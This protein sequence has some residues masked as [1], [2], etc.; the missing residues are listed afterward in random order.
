MEPIAEAPPH[1]K[2]RA[3]GVVYLLYFLIA[4]PAQLLTS[5]GL[6]TLGKG[7]NLVGFA[8]YIALTLLLYGLFKPVN[9]TLSLLAA[10]VSLL[11]SMVGI[12]D[13][14]HMAPSRISP[15]WF[16]GPYCILIGW[17]ILRSTFLPRILGAVMLL[18]GVS[19]LAYLSPAVAHAFSHWIE[20]LGILAEGSLMLWLLVKGV[21]ERRWQEQAGRQAALQATGTT[22]EAPP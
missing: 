13:L 5:R 21:D 11:G 16:F 3:I 10:I 20:G 1:S 22:V 6:V 12:L 14:F 7:V 8:D 4:M 15:L 19:W 17:L 18:A 9:R 2:A